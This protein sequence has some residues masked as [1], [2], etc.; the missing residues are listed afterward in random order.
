MRVVV[1][2][3]KHAKV[4]VNGEVVGSIDHGLV[5]L[6]GV[7]HSDTVEDAAFIADKI[8]HLRIFE[9]ESGKMNLSVLDVGGEILSVSQFTLYGD[10]RKGRRPNFMEAAK[11]DRA[12]P[13][14]EAMNEALRQKGI[15]VETGKFGAMMEV[16]LINDG[17]VTLIVESK[18]KAGNK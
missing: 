1:Q 2:R 13:I 14:Y 4:T 3:A 16:E 11:P 10:C 7:T 18:E 5:L 9:D 15:R 6:V 17:P 12:L 8:A